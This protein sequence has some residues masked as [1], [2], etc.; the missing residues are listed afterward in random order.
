MPRTSKKSTSPDEIAGKASRGEDISS[1]FTNKFNVVRPVHR[2]NIDLIP[3]QQ[4]SARTRQK[5]KAG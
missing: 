3:E 1:H 4:R 5:G 2:V